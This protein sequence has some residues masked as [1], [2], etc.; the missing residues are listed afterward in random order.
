M[1]DIFKPTFHREV[2]LTATIVERSGK[3]FARFKNSS[4]RV[5]EGVLIGDGQ[6]CRVETS[7]FYGRIKHPDGRTRRVPLGVTDKE[8]ARQLRIKLQKQADQ[9]KAGIID[10]FAGHLRRPLI[11]S[12]KPLPKRSHQRDSHGRIAKFASQLAREDIER[13]IVGSH[14]EDYRSHLQGAGRSVTHIWEILRIIRRV[15][16]ACK[17]HCLGDLEAS[18]LDKYLA[19]LIVDGKSYRTRNAALKSVRAFVRWLVKS[20]R[21]LKDPFKM[22]SAVN[23]QSDPNRRQRRP[24]EPSEFTRLIAA[25]ENGKMIESISGSERAILYLIAAWTGLRRKELAAITPAN[26]SLDREPPCVHIRAASTKAK[27]DDQPIPLHPVVAQKL[28]EWL[29][30]RNSGPNERIF[31]LMTRSGRLRKT[32]KMMEH[33]CTAADLPYVGD[34]GVADFHSH[35]MAFITN[36]CRTADFSTVVDLARHSDPKLTSKIYD[37]VRLENRVAA[38][39]SLMPPGTVG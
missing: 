6:R 25:A 31:H 20:D 28:R 32:S 7:E 17:F 22:L 37:R 3:K 19:A 26:L 1:A 5:V 9:Q 38:I 11:G 15:S 14:L 33:D 2:P 13:A 23:E 29:V 34:L 4:G 8:A 35:R 21:L 39:N 18:V 10:P 36:L 16:I 12:A 24:L 27:R 30:I